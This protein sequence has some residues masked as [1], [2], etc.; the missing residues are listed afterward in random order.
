MHIEK[1][2]HSMTELSG[3]FQINKVERYSNKKIF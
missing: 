3:E 1:A 2:M